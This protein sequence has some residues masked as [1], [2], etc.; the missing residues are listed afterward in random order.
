MSQYDSLVHS[1][2][3]II[4]LLQ[5]VAAGLATLLVFAMLGWSMA[6]TRL[7]LHYPPDLTA[8]AVQQ[9]G[10]V[11]KA[12]IYGFTFYI[13]QQLN[14]WAEDGRDDYYN[15]IHRLKNYMTPSCFEDRLSDYDERDNRN[16]LSGRTRAVWEI[17]GRGFNVKRVV[18][19][20]S[21]SWLVGLDLHVQESYR[22]ERIKDRLIHFPIKVVRYDVDPES[23]AWGLALNC[24]A[25]S[26]RRIEVIEG[27]D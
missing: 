13:F 22:G 12:N 14:R 8:G 26:P 9:A 18:A 5:V 15:Q 27:D 11:P 7:T 21:N 16:E 3:R 23:N 2:D 19:T 17:P 6:P 4:L 25:T 10:E 24:Y 20:S 1:K